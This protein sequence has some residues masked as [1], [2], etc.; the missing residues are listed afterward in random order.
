MSTEKNTENTNA[1]P[2][3]TA[4][5]VVKKRKRRLGDR[6][7]GYK[8][9]NLDLP[10]YIIPVVMRTRLDSQ[11]F[12]NI[13]IDIDDIEKYVRE[14]R[15]SDI[16][17]LKLL[18]VV[19]AAALRMF[20]TRPQLNRFVAGKKIYAHNDIS[21]SMSIKRNLTDDGEETEVC[22]V[23]ER[24]DTLYD[25]VKKFNGEVEK[26]FADEETDTDKLNRIVGMT[27]T[28]IKS[29]IVFVLRNLDKVGLMPK[30]ITKASPFHASA[31]ITDVGS[32]GIDS[33]YHH[34]YEFG[35]CSCF[36]AMGKKQTIP[37]IK[38][39]GTLGQKKVINFR[40]VLDERITDGHYYAASLRKFTRYMKHPELL[41]LPP[42]ELP[43]EI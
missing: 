41:E 42:E 3:K 19:M 6:H 32:L 20:A 15:R 11:V 35:T 43:D 26:A 30:F 14:K 9:R 29:F 5:P 39:D 37:C 8:V 4:K 23:F 1:T 28:C 40:F 24:T 18:H 7:D 10:F 31:Y 38:D 16:P 21:F 36:I 22:P 17:N 13:S 34:L 25:V 27:P 2:C 12:F 33:I